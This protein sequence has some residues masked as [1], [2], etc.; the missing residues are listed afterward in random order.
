MQCERILI[1]LENGYMDSLLSF[2][3]FEHFHNFKNKIIEGLCYWI[4][5]YGEWVYWDLI[6]QG[7]EAIF[8][9]LVIFLKKNH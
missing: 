3:M 6:M 4:L 1:T 5:E 8:K 7:I 9:I 2:S